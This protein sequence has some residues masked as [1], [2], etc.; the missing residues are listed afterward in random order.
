[1]VKK[2]ETL[3]VRQG[4]LP[5]KVMLC[6]EPSLGWPKPKMKIRVTKNRPA[7]H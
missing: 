1:M 3:A 7:N 4:N 5:I 6:N 2:V